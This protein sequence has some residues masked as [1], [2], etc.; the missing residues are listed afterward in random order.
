MKKFLLPLLMTLS[1][2]QAATIAIIDSGLDGEHQGIAPQLWE[3]AQFTAS[4]RFQ[5]VKHGWDFVRNNN[6]IIDRSLFKFF[7]SPDIT[8]FYEIRAKNFLFQNTEEDRAWAI[9]KQ[10]DAKFMATVRSFGTFAHG[11]HVGGIA[12]K[13]S[14]NT[15]MGVT[16]LKTSVAGLA[17]EFEPSFEKGLE[18]DTA[19]FATFLASAAERSQ[20][21][22]VEIGQFVGLHKAD[23]ANGSYGTSFESAMGL[24]IQYFP[25]F[26]GRMGTEAEYIELAKVFMNAQ[27]KAG[28]EFVAAAPNTLF[29]FAA[30]NDSTNNDEFPFSPA[31][32]KADNVITVAATYQDEFLAPFSN[33][34]VEMVE[35]AAPGMLIQSTAPDGKTI[36]MSG[37][38]QAAPHVSNIAGQ[39][40][41]AN[42]ALRPVDIKTILMGTVD[43]KDFL[44]FHVKTGGIVS[45]ERAVLA[46]ELSRKMS[47]SDAIEEALKAIPQA[48]QKSLKRINPAL[49]Q[50]KADEMT[51]VF[52]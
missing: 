44:T 26:V 38:S 2:A 31:N 37:T 29:V 5:N 13:D 12:I 33:Y 40:K 7:T 17:A 42:S 35:V 16:L 19:E 48:E 8:R 49:F 34:G 27:V 30:G 4:P 25:V 39:I 41:D 3:N 21:S 43:K 23:I 45:R 36:S 10:K 20:K 51:A 50:V 47:V 9:E 11:T 24:V 28:Q 18:S 52:E 14:Q 1:S 6:E 46:A 32:I 15:V 22:M